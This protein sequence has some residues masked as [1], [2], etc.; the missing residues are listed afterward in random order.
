MPGTDLPVAER[1]PSPSD[2]TAPVICFE[3]VAIAFAGKTFCAE[4]EAP[5]EFMMGLSE[6]DTAIR[7]SLPLTV[8]VLN[9]QGDLGVAVT[10]QRMVE[11]DTTQ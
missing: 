6:L 2:G 1:K 4:I 7:Y 5:G 9:D 11:H 8:F 10:L 3:D